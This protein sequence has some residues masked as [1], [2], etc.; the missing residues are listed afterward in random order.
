LAGKDGKI[1][2]LATPF[3]GEVGSNAVEMEPAKDGN[4]VF[5]TLDPVIQK[6]VERMALAATKD[7]RADGIA[8]TIIDPYS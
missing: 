1:V 5:L 3:I 7:F 2:G 6:E 8:V 4:N